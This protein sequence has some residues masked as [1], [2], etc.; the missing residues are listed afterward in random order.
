MLRL[1]RSNIVDS[2]PGDLGK[3]E[4]CLLSRKIECKHHSPST[5]TSYYGISSMEC[6]DLSGCVNC[7]ISTFY[8]SRPSGLRWAYG[9]DGSGRRARTACF[10]GNEGV[11][12]KLK[13]LRNF[14]QLSP[15]CF[16]VRSR[17][18]FC[19]PCLDALNSQLMNALFLSAL[20]HP[21]SSTRHLRPHI[22]HCNY[23]TSHEDRDRGRPHSPRPSGFSRHSRGAGPRCCFRGSCQVSQYTPYLRPSAHLVL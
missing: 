12:R 6:S 1:R 13:V 23:R 14:A 5:T 4:L 19:L 7:T 8:D 3:D 10:L 11:E 17:I 16:Q 9:R 2:F 18:L 22:R 20:S 15:L 21:A